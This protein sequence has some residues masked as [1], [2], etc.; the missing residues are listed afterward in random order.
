MD[1]D[2][3]AHR[4]P[5][6]AGGK[7]LMGRYATGRQHI[8]ENDQVTYEIGNGYRHYHAASMAVVLTGPKVDPRHRNM[9]EACSRP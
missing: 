9:H 3:P 6:G 8:G 7:A 5:M 4:W 2:P 1:G